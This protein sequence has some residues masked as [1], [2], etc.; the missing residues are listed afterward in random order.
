MTKQEFLGRYLVERHGT[1]SLKWDAL[2][3]MYGDKDLISMWIAD[4]EFKTCDAI[5]E[6]LQR[7]IKHGVFGYTGLPEGYCDAFSGWMERHY[8]LKLEKEWFRFSTGCVTA[9]AWLIN[10]FTYPGDACL[11]L[12]PVYYPFRS[13]VKNNNRQLVMVD[14]KYD[15]NGYF[16][17]D[18]DAMER[19]IVENKVK[20]FIQCSP[21]NPVGR[22]WREEE[23]ESVLALCRKH[24][25]LVVSDEIHQDIILSGQKFTPVAAVAGGAYRDMTIT[26]TAASKTFNLASLIHSH[27]LIPDANLRETYDRFSQALNRTSRNLLGM[28]AAQAG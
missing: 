18:L 1:D 22:V 11:I 3:R 25:V 20:L 13:V 26:V 15:E 24:Q 27:I 28:T 10:A 9:L 6:A 14:L 4:S 2:E 21:H 19:A 8:G 23:L 7:R 16:T 5:T 12:T 17:I